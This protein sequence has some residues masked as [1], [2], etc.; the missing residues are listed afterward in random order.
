MDGVAAAD[1]DMIDRF[2]ATYHLD[3]AGGARGDG[4]P[5]ARARPHAGRHDRAAHRARPPR[6]R[7]DAGPARRGRRPPLGARDRLRLLEDARPP[8][9]GQPG[10]RH[11][12]QGRPAAARRRRRDRR[13]PRLRRDRD[14]AARRAQRLVERA[15]LR[16]RRRGRPLGHAVPVLLRGGR[17]AADRHGAAS[18]PTPRPS[19]ST[20]PRA[21][22]ST[23]TTRPGPRPSSP[24]PTPRAASR[25]APPPA[26]APSC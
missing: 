3:P 1:F 17:G 5:V 13:R 4:D 9:A 15:R 2:I 12:R 22:S 25:C 21:P 23:A 16:R 19:R 18:P 26:P 11:Q 8:H 14:H 6:P 7:P 24:P 10:P 20:A